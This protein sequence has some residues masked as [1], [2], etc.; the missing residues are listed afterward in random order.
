M[1]EISSAFFDIESCTF[2]LDSNAT[3]G[4]AIKITRAGSYTFNSL[5]FNGFGA[6]GTNKA[7]IYND[8]GSSVSISVIDGAQPTVRNGTGSTTTVLIQ[9]TLT[10]TGLKPN[11]EVRIFDAGTTTELAGVENSGTSF[12]ANISTNSVD[13]VIHALG[14]EY[15]R[16]L[17]V[18]TSNS[19]SLPIQQRVARNYRN[20]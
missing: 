13:I 17:N 7:S 4:H 15:Q 14:Y 2:E 6:D 16:I 1:I 5:T 9:K 18:D 3:F 12:S 20:D 19:L 11:T 8:S 10:L